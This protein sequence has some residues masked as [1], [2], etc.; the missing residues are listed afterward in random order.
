VGVLADTVLVPDAQELVRAFEEEL[1]A[2]RTL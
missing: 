2:L 1:E